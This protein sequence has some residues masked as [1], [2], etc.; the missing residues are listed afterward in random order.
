M[1]LLTFFLLWVSDA[2]RNTAIS[3][4]PAAMALSRPR[5]LGTRAENC[6]ESRRL[7][8]R[9]TSDE[10]ASWGIH[11]GLTKL[12]I[13]IRSRPVAD[14]ASIKA[15]FFGRGHLA[16]LVLQA[17]ARSDLVDRYPRGQL[18]E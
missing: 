13:S 14:R 8:P 7:T 15:I 17:V 2:D 11:L 4:M 5:R 9:A 1:V 18:V 12:V 6:T 16:G 3:L 10:S